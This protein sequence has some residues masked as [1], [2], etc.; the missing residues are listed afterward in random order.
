MYKHGGTREGPIAYSGTKS[1]VHGESATPPV[2]ASP[3]MARVCLACI[4]GM[5][6]MTEELFRGRLTVLSQCCIAAAVTW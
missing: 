6:K 4:N 5:G 3:T 1:L 2:T